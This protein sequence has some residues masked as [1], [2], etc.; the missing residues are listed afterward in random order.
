[1]KRT[2]VLIGFAVLLA[3]GAVGPRAAQAQDP[4]TLLERARAGG[5]TQADVLE[6]LRQ[7]GLSR[8]QVRSQLQQAGVDP[9]LADRY[10]DALE[11]GE[12]LPDE[13][14]SPEFLEAV[15]GMGVPVDS[16]ADT[17]ERAPVDTLDADTPAVAVDTLAA[18][19][20]RDLAI[21]GRSLFAN[22]TSEFEPVALGPVDPDYRLGPGDQ[23][24]LV[25]TGDVELAY[26]L[27]VSREGTLIIPDVGRLQVNGLTLAELEDRLYTRLGRAYSGLTREPDA[28]THFQVSL[29][30]LHTNQVFVIGEVERPAG[31]Q[32][33]AIATVFNALY[34]AR[35]PGETGS[36]RRIEVR[37]SGEVVR[38]VDLYDYLLRGDDRDDIRLMHGDIVFV[39]VAG[40]RVS[41]DGAVRRPAIYELEED[42]GLRDLIEYAAG[43][44]A[45]AVVERVQIDRILAP[46][47][48]RPGVDRVLEDVDVEALL[49]EDGPPIPLRDGDIVRIFSVGDERRRRIV[50]TGG[51]NRPGLFEWREEMTL[52]DAI[53]RANG[54]H[55]RAYRARAHIYRLRE[56]DGSQR[57]IST[58]LIADSAGRPLRDV[59]LADRDSIVILS[60]DEL[61]N[62]ALVTIDGFV[63]DPGSYPLAEGMTLEDLILA[64]G[65]FTRGA[66]VLEAEVAR[67]P[68]PLVRTDTTAHVFRVPL[69]ALAEPAD[70]EP[71]GDD[72]LAY[73]PDA[74]DSVFADPAAAVRGWRPSADELGLRH[75]DHVFIRKAPGYE[76][77]HTVT[78]TGE[79]ALPGT[80]ALR[81]R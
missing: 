60:R 70:P 4:S 63:K 10:F 73:A 8:S 35:G 3:G 51:V 48:R 75:G 18:D 55:E 68:D 30:R 34:R 11:N 54:L 16:P 13:P 12:E 44:E 42:D 33:S 29:G 65:G 40:R 58:P 59:A 74:A 39:P 45:D 81:T 6:R 53:E 78:V 56:G 66:Y 80:Y 52:W 79:V 17:T 22:A 24:T 47:D 27:S 64:A 37:R 71:A 25:L 23:L 38:T 62:E 46:E 31:Y 14:P 19:T 21:F 2:A 9:G 41:I 28:T 67:L 26:N 61:R 1:M 77:A 50:L 5:L 69:S 72:P 76:E 7:S 32:V 57:L 15:D 43:F 36:M 49:D 20:A